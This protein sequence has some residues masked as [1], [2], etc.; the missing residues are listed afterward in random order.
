MNWYGLQIAGSPEDLK[1]IQSIIAG[2]GW[3]HVWNSLH[4]S[5]TPGGFEQILVCLSF[6]PFWFWDVGSHVMGQ[7][8]PRGEVL[9]RYQ[10][11]VVLG[12]VGR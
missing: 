8:V 9:Y 10:A 11:E 5:P 2:P 1:R 12:M 4:W 3:D 6:Q 7:M